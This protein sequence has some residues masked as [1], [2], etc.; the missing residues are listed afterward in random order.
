MRNTGLS[1]RALNG[2]GDESPEGE[3]TDGIL[4]QLAKFERAKTAERMRRG[5]LRKAREGKLIGGHAPKYGF[6]FNG[7]RTGYVLDE[8]NI[9]VVRHIF[10]M[11]VSEAPMWKVK[12]TL[13]AEGVPAPNGG[14]RWSPTTL[15]EIIQEDSYRPHTVEELAELVPATV[16][17]SLDPEKR[18]GSLGT[19]DVEPD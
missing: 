5:K 7:D 13:E 4:D 17:N 12:T 15:R 9:E 10:E 11:V 3:L 2:R 1:I 8:T 19:A 6:Q 16:V 18:Y 14:K